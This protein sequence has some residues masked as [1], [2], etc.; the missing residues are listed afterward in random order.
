MKK[1]GFL[2]LFGIIFLTSCFSKSSYTTPIQSGVYTS[3]ESFSLDDQEYTGMKAIFVEISNKEFQENKPFNTL[4]DYALSAKERKY[5]S[6]L[7]Y[8]L[9]EETEIPA[10]MQFTKKCNPYADGPNVYFLTIEI[11]HKE[12][13]LQCFASLHIQSNQEENLYLIY[14]KSLE[15]DISLFFSLH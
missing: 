4:E 1:V 2:I 6:C 11:P 7:F 9:Q 12:E 13:V 3:N 10:P 15:N 5:Y 8:F 14:I